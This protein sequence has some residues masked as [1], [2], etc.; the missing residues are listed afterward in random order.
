MSFGFSVGDFLAV[1]RLIN[2]VIDALRSSSTSEFSELTREL[3]A[4]QHSLDEIEHLQPPPGQELAVNAIK[5]AALLCQ[6]PLD[7]FSKKL[8]KYEALGQ[9]GGTK[10]EQV[11]KWRLKLQWGF[12]MEEEVQK[13]RV[14]LA[15]HMASLNVR[16]STCGL[17]SASI[18]V[19]KV[20][21]LHDRLTHTHNAVLGIEKATQS[22]NVASRDTKT[23]LQTLLSLLQHNLLPKMEVLIDLANRLWT[24]NVQ[25]LNL[26][27]RIQ[28]TNATPDVQHTYFQPPCQFE[29]ALG[30]LLIVP[31][32]TADYIQMLRAIISARF[33]SGPGRDKV[34]SGEYEIFNT[35]D[36]S[37]L[38]SESDGQ[39][40]VPGM[41]IT[42][43]FVIGR[44][45]RRTLHQC[46]RPGCRAREFKRKSAGGRTCTA[47]DV[48]FDYSK[49]SIPRPFRLDPTRNV[50]QTL[51]T[52][53]KWFK[54]VKICPS[55][56]PGLPPSIDDRGNVVKGLT[57]KPEMDGQVI[58]DHTY[59]PTPSSKTAIEGD[60]DLNI[61]ELV[62][63]QAIRLVTEEISM[64]FGELKELT[65]A[66]A[67]PEDLGIDSLLAVSITW[68]FQELGIEPPTGH[69][70][71]DP[72]FLESFI[73]KLIS[74][75]GHFLAES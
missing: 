4:V 55:D 29:D 59:H 31:S 20:D 30:R 72:L 18:A 48:W 52:E 9:V 73:R 7:D 49:D 58:E 21:C 16:I 25:I 70:F 12:T 69:R 47:C 75:Y 13:I 35:S 2:D 51:R 22:Q 68:R 14:I 15:A 27:T 3:H 10:K 44:Y 5:V 37:Q 62:A 54:N 39:S 67:E 66:G 17:T 61:P 34:Q 64:N 50:F 56:I 32:D 6:H 71:Y 24:S 65:S 36:N 33:S 43:A 57:M 53:R 19:Q 28:Y 63:T 38:L 41:K 60:F 74:Q 8:A 11:K 26:L 1:A 45:Q 42:M 23:F 46:P 40:L